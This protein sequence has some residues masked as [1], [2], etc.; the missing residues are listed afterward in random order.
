MEGRVKKPCQMSISEKNLKDTVTEIPDEVL[1]IWEY[2]VE[3]A[4]DGKE[5]IVYQYD[6]VRN[7]MSEIGQTEGY[8]HQQK[9]LNIEEVFEAN[10]WE[11]EYIMED[12]LQT[13]IS[14]YWK[15]K[16]KK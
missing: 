4:F 1:K 11:V 9:W 2:E 8:I 15:F 6:I 3:K 14:C 16:A 10:D 7:I 5:A 12:C 13:P